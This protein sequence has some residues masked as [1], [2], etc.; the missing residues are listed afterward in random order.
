MMKESAS[1]RILILKAALK[2]LQILY[3]N[4]L[5]FIITEKILKT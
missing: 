3:Y 1:V 2:Y 4:F 5:L